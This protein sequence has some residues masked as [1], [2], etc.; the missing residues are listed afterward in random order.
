MQQKMNRN[1]RE[2]VQCQGSLGLPAMIAAAAVFA[3]GGLTLGSG[4]AGTPGQDLAQSAGSGDRFDMLVRVDFFSGFAGDAAAL[5]RGMKK[6]EEALAKDPKNAEALVWHGS[7]LSYSAKKEFMAGNY[8]KGREIQAR[9]VAEMNEAV[10]LHPDDVAVLIPRASVFLS[11]ALHVPLP[12]VA[13]KDFRI[14]ADDYEKVLHLQAAYFSE[15]P[16]HARGEL[17]GGLA[18]AWNGLGAVE[19]SRGYQ[20]RMAEELKDS[21][22]AR[23]AEEVL[24]SPSKSGPL[25][26]TC[27]GCHVGNASQK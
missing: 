12:E 27:L 22:Y 24:A 19:K 25:G 17:L 5:E 21:P 10:A 1:L 4:V 8:E 26:T 6:C 20:M 18:E 9:G 3:M 11:A 13:R 14:A 2:F 23:R 16:I 15:L 7:G